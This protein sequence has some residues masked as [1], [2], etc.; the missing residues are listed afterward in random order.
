MCLA[1]TFKNEGADV[2][3]DSSSTNEYHEAWLVDLGAYSH[4]N[5]H[6]KWVCEYK[7]YN[8]G[9][10]FLSDDSTTKIII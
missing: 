2:Y 7:K 3:L 9:D 6:R 1:K 10:V 8:G 4:M 5:P